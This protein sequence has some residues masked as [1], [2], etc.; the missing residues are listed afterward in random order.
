ML[1]LPIEVIDIVTQG[2]INCITLFQYDLPN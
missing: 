1:L 2:G